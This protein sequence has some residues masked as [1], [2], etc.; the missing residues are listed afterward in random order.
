[1]YGQVW[2]WYGRVVYDTVTHLD[3]CYGSLDLNRVVIVESMRLFLIP[4]SDQPVMQHGVT[5]TC[6]FFIEY[7]IL[8]R[9]MFDQS[10]EYE[11][12]VV[13]RQPFG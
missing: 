3:I 6:L 10:V 5:G 1:M 2:P 11:Q 7:Y 9:Y 12:G 8:L 13:T 4:G